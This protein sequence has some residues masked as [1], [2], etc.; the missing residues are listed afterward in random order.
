[1]IL[2]PLFVCRQILLVN[3]CHSLSLVAIFRT[4]DQA[5]Q[6]YRIVTKWWAEA[7]RLNSMSI[8]CGV[9]GCNL[10]KPQNFWYVVRPI[11]FPFTSDAVNLQQWNWNIQWDWFWKF[12]KLCGCWLQY[13]HFCACIKEA[14]FLSTLYL[15]QWESTRD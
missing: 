12:I 15:P 10:C 5:D 11:V 14:V 3:H 2:I 7:Y 1:M 13:K 6:S 8:G 4:T 9:T